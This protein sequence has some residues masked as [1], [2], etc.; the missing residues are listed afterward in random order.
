MTDPAR[1]STIKSMLA[2]IVGALTIVAAALLAGVLYMSSPV[3]AG[4]IGILIVFILIYMVAAGLLTFFIFGMS[5]IT[6]VV[7]RV[8]VTSRPMQSLTFR[9]S[10]YFASIV[11]VAPVALLGMLSISYV[12]VYEVVLVTVLV[13]LGCFYI[14]WRGL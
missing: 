14:T 5:Y 10:Y 6:S 11:A 2:K 13:G 3:T 1:H 7:A 4:P 12:S 9:R 8:V